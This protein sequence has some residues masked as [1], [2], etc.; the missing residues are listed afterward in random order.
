MSLNI[1]W[2]CNVPTPYNDY[3]FQN[4]AADPE[5]NLTV[6]FREQN[7]SSYPWTQPMAQGFQS[8][9]Y[10][11]IIGLDWELIKIAT[12]DI[13][14]IFIIG[15]WNHPALWI[16]LG[17][18]ILRKRSFVIWTDTPN[19]NKS[20][21]G[22]IARLRSIWLNWIFRS[23]Y[24]I[25]G[26]G[27]PCVQIFNK[28]G[29]PYE[30]IINFSYW[31]P[32]PRV[33]NNR[34]K[35][36]EDK[37]TIFFS[38]GRL[39]PIKGFDLSI[40]AFEIVAGTQYKEIV[41]FWIFGDGPE[42]NRLEL[43]ATNAGLADRVKFWGWQSP[44]FIQDKIKKADVLVHPAIWEPYGVVVLEAMAL[45]KPV[46]GSNTTMAVLDRIM[47]GVN[48]FVHEPGDIKQIAEQLIYFIENPDKIA[49]MGREA[50]TVAEQWPVEVGVDVIKGIARQDSVTG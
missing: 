11:K 45:G 2:L 44:S 25:M 42:R 1:H 34:R 6:H 49:L 33:M 16:V 18:L 26:T 31:V 27:Q 4:L 24:A 29:V 37:R 40:K 8:R 43:M 28:M 15:G 50:R 32:L 21:T 14:S 20:R 41:E 38:I 48:G 39:I 19:I 12:T 17:I 13:R 22:L 3:L 10:K 30:K 36:C 47:H 5:I 35:T 23:A 7:I 9:Y 46:I